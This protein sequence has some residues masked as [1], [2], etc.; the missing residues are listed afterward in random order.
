VIIHRCINRLERHR[1]RTRAGEG[2]Q[3]ARD[4]PDTLGALATHTR[5]ED[6]ELVAGKEAGNRELLGKEAAWVPRGLTRYLPD[7]GSRHL[8]GVGGAGLA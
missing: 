3:E 6:R 5:N 7:A 1:K 8:L 2:T 4:P